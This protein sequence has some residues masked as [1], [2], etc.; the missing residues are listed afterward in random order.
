MEICMKN[1]ECTSV[2]AGNFAGLNISIVR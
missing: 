1:A 2:F